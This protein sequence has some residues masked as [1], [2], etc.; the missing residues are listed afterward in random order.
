MS[1]RVVNSVWRGEM[2]LPMNLVELLVLCR[3]L[4]HVREAKLQWKQPQ[5]L[6]IRFKDG[7]TMLVFKSGKFRVMGGKID[8]LDA[9]FNIYRVTG[10][11]EQYPVIMIQTMT[12]TFTYPHQINLALLAMSLESHYNPEI[13]P[14][15][16][17]HIYK[18]IVANVFASGKVTILGLKDQETANDIQI[19]L[20]SVF[21]TLQ[22]KT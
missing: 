16:N 17:I 6:I 22:T 5:Q 3:T 9:H 18:P 21:N 7:S 19:K 15:V 20:T 8:D 10:L 13:F 4:D 14:A 12:A 1:V 11:L 2:Q